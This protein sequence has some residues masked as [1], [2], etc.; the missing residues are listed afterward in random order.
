MEPVDFLLSAITVIGAAFASVVAARLTRKSQAESNKIA[1]ANSV[2]TRYQALLTD[3]QEERDKSAA[4]NKFFRRQI[5]LWKRWVNNLRDQIYGL[6]GKPVE[7][8]EELEL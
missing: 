5:T 1:E 7:G 6:G 3:L 2:I 4:D 8:D